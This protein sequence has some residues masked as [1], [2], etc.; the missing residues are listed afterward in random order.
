MSVDRKFYGKSIRSHNYATVIKEPTVIEYITEY[1]ESTSSSS[2]KET[3]KMGELSQNKY[4]TQ[5]NG[6]EE[7]EEEEIT[8][9]K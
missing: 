3:E 8:L 4:P 5:D 2:Q 1:E 7:E 6:E 9:I